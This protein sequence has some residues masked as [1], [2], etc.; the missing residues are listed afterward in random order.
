MPKG[1]NLAGTNLTW[2][3]CVATLNRIDMLEHCVA[4]AL[5]QTWPPTEIVIVDASEN[6]QDNRDRIAV[7]T[8]DAVSLRYLP[9]PLR[10]STVQRNIGIEAC[11]ADIC[12]LIDDDSLMHPDCAE[13]IMRAY[14][15]D[16]EGEILGIAGVPGPSPLSIK[17]VAR[18]ESFANSSPAKSMHATKFMRFLWRELFLMGRAVNFVPYA[19]PVGSYVP[20]WAAERGLDLVPA[21]Q[22]PGCRMT[23]RRSAGLREPFEPAFRSYSPGEDFD[24][25]YRLSRIGAICVASAARIYH[26]EVAASRIRREQELV[27]SICNVAY[28]I[29]RHSPDIARDRRRWSVLMIRRLL[30]EL[31]KDGL[32]QR[33]QLP[34]L[35]AAWKA[36]SLG[37][38]ILTFPDND[39]LADHYVAIQ[40]RILAAG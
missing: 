18:K 12:M 29:R 28:L 32:S 14:T 3:L 11:T 13:I 20:G 36:A 26:H 17:D 10:S 33:W 37:R 9:A 8:S 38:D 22:L 4:C 27:L 19:G 16:K 7:L 39:R 23:I 1:E 5:S 15:A 31:L 2:A 25:S 24:I 40:E 35:R 21:V 34:Q 6:W 30:A